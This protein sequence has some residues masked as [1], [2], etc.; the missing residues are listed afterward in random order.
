M[1]DTLSTDLD[2]KEFANMALSRLEASPLEIELADR[3]L[4]ALTELDRLSMIIVE[5]GIYA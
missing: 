2:D 4:A 3:L 1:P 5:N